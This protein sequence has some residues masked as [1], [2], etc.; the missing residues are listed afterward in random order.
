[1]KNRVEGTKS[2]LSFFCEKRL[3]PAPNRTLARGR[4]ANNGWI[5]RKLANHPHLRLK[6]VGFT[7]SYQALVNSIGS[8]GGT[9]I[10]IR[11]IDVKD[12]QI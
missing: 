4:S 1:M 10:D 5:I 11:S 6:T 9:A 7:V 3:K 8:T 2:K 12:V